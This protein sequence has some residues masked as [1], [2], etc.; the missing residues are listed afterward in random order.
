MNTA[1]TFKAGS[2]GVAYLSS[3]MRKGRKEEKG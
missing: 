3:S 2:G 1:V